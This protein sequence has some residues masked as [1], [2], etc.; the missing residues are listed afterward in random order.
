MVEYPKSLN[1]FHKPTIKNYSPQEMSELRLLLAL[2]DSISLLETSLIEVSK[3]RE[4]E[5]YKV[6]LKE[7][8][9]LLDNLKNKWGITDMDMTPSTPKYVEEVVAYD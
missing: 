7:S 3:E 8:Y 6:R 2:P 1:N 4:K 9:D 5:F